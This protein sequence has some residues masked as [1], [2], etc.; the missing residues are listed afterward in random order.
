[1]R[2]S[3]IIL[4]GGFSNRFGQDKGLL[5]LGDRPLIIRI[6][7]KVSTLVDEVLV[8]V[9]S[10][11]QKEDYTCLDSTVEIVVDKYR[12]Q[13]PVVG[14]LSGFERAQGEYSLLLPCDTPF[15]SRE[16]A[17]LLLKSCIGSDAAIPRW[18]KDHIEPLQA[19]YFTESALAASK[20][21]LQGEKVSMHLL[22]S[23]L[24]KVRYVSTS[25]IRQMDPKLMTFFNVNSPEDLG[26]AERILLAGF[27][28]ERTKSGQ[29]PI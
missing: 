18:P 16:V 19:A 17:E 12:I 8:V 27:R 11:D 3:A 28:E 22:I 2:K 5:R 10:V 25:S 7:D 26:K 13:S 1:M 23:Y 20:K 21:A 9:N 15:V 24:E 6:L 4:A 29:Q 14:A